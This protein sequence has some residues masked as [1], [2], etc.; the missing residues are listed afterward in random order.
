[1]S[2]P[3]KDFLPIR[4]ALADWDHVGSDEVFA[5]SGVAPPTLSIAIPTFQR[6][7]MLVQAVASALAQQDAARL[8][9]E[10]VVVDNDPATDGHHRLVEALPGLA[11]ANFRYVVNRENIGG[12]G[13]FNR[14]VQVARGEWLTLLHDDDLLD[15]D[16]ATK[17]MAI[18]A[19]HPEIDGLIC[20]K[21]GSDQRDEQYVMSRRTIAL[22]HAYGWYRYGFGRLRRITARKLF[23]GCVTGNSVGFICRTEAVRALGGFYPEEYPSPDYFFYARFAERYHFAETKDTLATIRVAVNSLLRKDIQLA[24][25]RRSYEIQSAYAGTVLP[26]FWARLSPMV[27]AR[28]VARTS[29]YWRSSISREEMEG[30]IGVKVARDRPMLV[31]A[32]RAL[33][34]GL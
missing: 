20:Q 17:M 15:P 7:D 8:G 19:A 18:L 16:F 24:C 26:R 34:G 2:K 27:M 25:L 3:S 22:R 29:T 12:D 11:Q 1:M 30:A 31:Y 10:I 33:L 32:L 5:G 13:N 4:N 9:I 14:C 23:W 28:Q 21:R 6:F